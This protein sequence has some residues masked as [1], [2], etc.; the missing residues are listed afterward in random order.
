MLYR[1][2]KMS[3]K[4]EENDNSKKSGK[5]KLKGQEILESIKQEALNKISEDPINVRNRD[6]SCTKYSTNKQSVETINSL[7][8]SEDFKYFDK[9]H[10]LMTEK[11]IR[12][13]K[14]ETTFTH[15]IINLKELQGFLDNYNE[16]YNN[17]YSR[18]FKNL[19]LNR[20]YV[21]NRQIYL[22]L[23]RRIIQKGQIPYIVYEMCDKETGWIRV[24]WSSHSPDERMNWYLF[25][26][27]SPNLP[28][29]MANIYY[30]MVSCGSKRRAL[31]RFDMKVRY[32]FP[33]KGEAQILEEF[34]TIFRNRANNLDGYDLTINN[35]YNKI[36]GDLFKQG[37]RG[38]FPSGSLNP[39]WS[40]V[41][42]ILLN[43]S[44]L[45][46]SEMN[47]LEALFRVSSKTIRRRFKAYGYGVKGTYDLKDSRAFLLKPI[48]IEGFKKALNQE[49]FFNYCET[50]GIEIFNRY[51]FIPNKENPRGSF[52]R[53]IIKQI[54]GTSKHKEARYLV[55]GD[56]ILTAITRINITP[57]EAEKEL[58]KIIDFKYAGEF[59][60][61]CNFIFDMDF[62]KKRDEIF[63]PLVEDLS[64]LYRN[65][66]DIQLK[67]AI[68]LGLCTENDPTEIRDRASHWVAQYVQRNYGVR[69]RELPLCLYPDLDEYCSFKKQ[70]FR[71]MEENPLDRPMDVLETF[72]GSNIENIRTYV[73]NWKKNN[74][75]KIIRY[76][77][78]LA[79][80]YIEEMDMDQDVEIR[81]NDLLT[82]FISIVDP[83]LNLDWNGIIAGAIYLACRILNRS[84]SQVKISKL[85][86]VDNHTLSKRYREIAE[87]LSIKL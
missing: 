55:L 67:I 23:V 46:G 47:E 40:D 62:I 79:S 38:S 7:S 2:I 85:V 59:A 77:N 25:R 31:A 44:V 49:N 35:Q 6:L 8:N 20:N 36:V 28:A 27:F 61:I 3:C 50:N 9:D 17:I 18:R 64:I 76:T 37:L 73:K 21:V 87:S 42:P 29:D 74:K 34:L 69:P 48:I 10:A 82:R 4:K 24:G 45:D 5:A 41:P 22:E 30:E 63:R 54:W 53:R 13:F 11:L 43:D 19:D 15:F 51:E 71:Y 86:G 57:G 56:Y 32:V 14:K 70:V 39:K 58:K 78:I 33:T 52:F 26:S 72:E 16:N 75:V 83:D 66:Y 60:R 1:E 81:S 12:L 65:E 80:E 68:D 84:I